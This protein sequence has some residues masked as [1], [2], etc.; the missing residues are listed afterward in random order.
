MIQGKS[1]FPLRVPNFINKGILNRLKWELKNFATLKEH[2]PRRSQ[3]ESHQ[4]HEG[5]EEDKRKGLLS[6][7]SF[8]S[9]KQSHGE[10]G[11]FRGKVRKS[12]IS[13]KA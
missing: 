2:N 12:T 13:E 1:G 4:L 9:D 7:L 10:E 8:W 11:A 5:R 3:A 6:K